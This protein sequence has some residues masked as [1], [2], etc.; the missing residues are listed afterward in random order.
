LPKEKRK[1]IKEKKTNRRKHS[2][3]GNPPVSFLLTAVLEKRLLLRW[4]WTDKAWIWLG[5][6]LTIPEKNI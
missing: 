4:I 2:E 6:G 3:A 1:E 5:L